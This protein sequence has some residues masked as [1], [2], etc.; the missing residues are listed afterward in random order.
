MLKNNMKKFFTFIIIFVLV[1]AGCRQK[2]TAG[3]IENNSLDKEA[4]IEQSA[5]GQNANEQKTQDDAEN[6]T[7]NVS[8][9]EGTTE[10]DTQQSEKPTQALTENPTKK[11][12]SK[13]TE[14][15]T[16]KPASKPTQAPTQAPTQKPTQ[17]PAEKPQE[18]SNTAGGSTDLK[19]QVEKNTSEYMSVYQEVLT[20]VNKIRSEAGVEP[21]QLDITLCK[22][23]GMR[24]LEMENAG[25][26]SHTRP[27]GSSCFTVLSE[28]GIG[29][30]AAGENIAAGY[31]NAA[32]V[33]EGWKNS[34]GHYE[35]MVNPNF[36]KLGVGLS[37]QNKDN[38]RIYWTQLFTS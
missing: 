12:A 10:K 27:D 28:Y 26:L 20:L 22:A 2:Q 13:P 36:K 17:K 33:V 8:N 32:S 11:P 30:M 1:I 37:K 4:T 38:Y 19:S 16:Q 3:N 7:E 14:A 9:G 35:N 15:S 24:S 6:T 23:A 21:L 34:K 5:N 31:P 18:S 29:Y 25:V